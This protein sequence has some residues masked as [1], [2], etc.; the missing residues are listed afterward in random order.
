[1][2]QK[3]FNY[4]DSGFL[5]AKSDYYWNTTYWMVVVGC[6]FSLLYYATDY[7]AFGKF[8]ILPLIARISLYPFLLVFIVLNQKIK[9]YKFRAIYSYVI[10][11]LLMWCT[12]WALSFR[13]NRIHANEGFMIIHVVLF[14]VGLS[15]PLKYSII[16]HGFFIVDIVVSNLFNHYESFALM[17]VISIPCIVG[18]SIVQYILTKSFSDYYVTR[19]QLE[20]LSKIDGLTKAYNRNKLTEITNPDTKAINIELAEQAGILMLD[21]DNFK[22][23]NDMYGHD[24]GD[25]TLIQFAKAIKSCIRSSDIVIRWG[26][27]EFVVILLGASKEVSVS[28]AEKIR[29]FVEKY[30]TEITPI[31]TSIGVAYYEGGNI[32][33]VIKKADIALY[34]AKNSGR[35]KV[36]C[37]KE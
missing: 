6:L 9:N 5:Q 18:L 21:L 11:H 31:T 30:E 35:N 12:I 32:H 20:R 25:V 34:Q 33:D 7:I 27:E 37:S 23:V 10:V 14:V 8:V 13:D 15:V 4:K 1:M 28:I 19:N 22:Q 17:L 16:G 2:D 26:G 3:K 24:S 29:L 36:V